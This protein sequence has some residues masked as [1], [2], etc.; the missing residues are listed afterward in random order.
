MMNN[1]AILGLLWGM[2]RWTLNAERWTLV[3]WVGCSGLGVEYNT[4]NV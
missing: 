2:E 1:K 4:L 3:A